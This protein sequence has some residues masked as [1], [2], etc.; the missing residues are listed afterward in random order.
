MQ[1]VLW[2]SGRPYT[3]A[4]APRASLEPTCCLKQEWMAPLGLGVSRITAW[5]LSGITCRDCVWAHRSEGKPGA[6]APSGSPGLLRSGCG[7]QPG[8]LGVSG[9]P[10]EFSCAQPKLNAL[11]LLSL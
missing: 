1:A 8:A 10:L 5:K 3:A 9:R 4:S 11:E 6:H 2:S 7:L